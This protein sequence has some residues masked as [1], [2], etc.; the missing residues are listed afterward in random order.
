MWL[1][2]CEIAQVHILDL[3]KCVFSKENK[4]SSNIVK[5]FLQSKFAILSASFGGITRNF[6]VI[7]FQ[8]SFEFQYFG[9]F[10]GC[11][12]MSEIKLICGHVKFLAL[13]NL[14]Y[15]HFWKPK[16]HSLVNARLSRFGQEIHTQMHIFTTY[17]FVWKYVYK[18]IRIN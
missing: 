15:K 17:T 14:C 4:N 18:F 5:S 7:W 8:T 9:L 10:S 6:T 12:M 13:I 2:P 16:Y 1:K 11:G 3:W